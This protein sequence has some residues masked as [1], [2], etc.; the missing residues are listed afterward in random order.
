[1]LEE[2]EK[3][4]AAK[5]DTPM[6]S[7]KANA[8]TDTDTGATNTPES[9]PRFHFIKELMEMIA[10]L[11]S[12]LKGEIGLVFKDYPDGTRTVFFGTKELVASDSSPVIEAPQ[13]Q[14]NWKDN[15]NMDV[16]QAMIDDKLLEPFNT[17][18]VRG[19]KLTKDF[20]SVKFVKYESS[21]GS[22]KAFALLGEEE[23]ILFSVTGRPLNRTNL[24]EY[25]ENH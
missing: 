25:R 15:P 13:K 11:I 5:T 12:I 14:K 9:I 23:G 10:V 20:S 1:M 17:A 4:P 2:K 6:F 18:D 7:V 21:F 24:R 16:L 22:M 19:L 3:K 8:G